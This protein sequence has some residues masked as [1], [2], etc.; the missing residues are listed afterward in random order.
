[1]CFVHAVRRTPRVRDCL[2]P[3]NGSDMIGAASTSKRLGDVPT[4]NNTAVTD[5]K[6]NATPV[7]EKIKTEAPIVG[8]QRLVRLCLNALFVL[9]VTFRYGA[10]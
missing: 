1:M 6:G 9:H 3:S 8:T 7:E 10:S 4:G 5:A 2:E